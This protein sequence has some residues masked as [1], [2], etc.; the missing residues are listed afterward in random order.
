MEDVF[1]KERNG[2]R[3][4][5]SGFMH[6]LM[7]IFIVAWEFSVAVLLWVGF[8]KM[9]G[10]LKA[11]AV[12]FK[13]GK[14]YNSF[15]LALGVLLWFT[16]LVTIGGVVPDVAIKN[17]ECTINR[18]LPNLLLYVVFNS[19]QPGRYLIKKIIVLS[20]RYC[21][22]LKRSQGIKPKEHTI[23]YYQGADASRVAGKP[24][25]IKQ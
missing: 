9:A 19:P 21:N 22:V 1:S 14:K 4:I 15:G 12:E 6:H 13:K 2:W 25:L 8:F 7:F 5:N 3:A 23:I 17:M 11:P 18:V 16:L 20:V 10:K 24:F